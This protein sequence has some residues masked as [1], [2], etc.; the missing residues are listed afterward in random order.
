MDAKLPNLPERKSIR[1]EGFDYSD[2]G[3]Y[4]ITLCA[5]DRLHIFWESTP[6]HASVGANC[7]RPPL[8]NAGIIV[9]N[10]IS[11]I[12]GTYES[13][14]IERHIVMPN[15]LHMILRIR[16]SGR[17]QFA[18]T[19]ESQDLT[20]QLNAAPT[21]SRI[22][23]QFKGSVSKQIGF[24]IWQRSFHDRIIRDHAE[25]LRFCSY[26]DENPARWGEDEYFTTG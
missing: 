12:S 7:V 1:L 17:T 15:H 25:Y 6:S 3:C 2:A 19:G 4:F 20:E 24:P 9:E 10:E 23:K 5:K 11:R 21:L 26:V 22:V 16:D 13:V 18:P 8:S 14:S